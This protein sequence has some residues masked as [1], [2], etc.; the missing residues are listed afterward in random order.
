VNTLDKIRDLLGYGI[1]WFYE[2]GIAYI[3]SLNNVKRKYCV[4]YDS[5]ACDCFEVHKADVTK[6]LFKPSKKRLFYS[7]V[8]NVI[9]LVT[10]V[11]D[12]INK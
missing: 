6:H 1:V 2:D 5:T 7:S 12:K 10:T 4:T 8:N 3:L 9:V 11:E